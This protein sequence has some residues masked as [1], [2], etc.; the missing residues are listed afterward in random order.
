MDAVFILTNLETH[1][2]FA[3]MAINAGKHVFIE[4]PVATKTAEI[5]ELQKLAEKHNV[6]CV[7]GHNMIH[8]SGI[9]RIKTMITAG[10][11]GTIVS[12]HVMYNMFHPEEIA[13]RYPG[14]IRQIFTHNLYTLIYLG[15]KP[16]KVSAFKTRLHYEEFDQ[17]DFAQA[18]L[19]M[20]S[21]ALAH[22]SASF[23]ADDLS[24][25]PWIFIIK[26]IGTK[27]SAR[28]SYQDW[29]EAAKD[30]FH[31]RTYTAYQSTVNNEVQY[32]IDV[33]TKGIL[34]LSTMEDATLAQRTMEAIEESIEK[35]KVV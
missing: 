21:G 7:P 6:Q 32:F 27:G 13:S 12:L 34:P 23:A 28:Y 5:I 30:A 8:E 22:I 19:L 29:V 20:E 15:G 11:L 26:V 24:A 31:T 3:K 1:V 9:K 16:K 2:Y 25:D 35:E 4:K 18:N 10:K 14:I 17:E 33:C